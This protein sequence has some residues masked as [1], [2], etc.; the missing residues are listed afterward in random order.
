MICLIVPAAVMAMGEHTV[1]KGGTIVLHCSVSG[2]P[3]LSILWTHVKSGKTWNQKKW[4]IEDIQVEKLG[5]Y[6]C[7]ASNKYG[8]EIKS[9][10]IFY[11]GECVQFLRLFYNRM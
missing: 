10:F 8:G 3:P 2:T 6:R 4:S 5:E 11:E 9:T 7:N 1:V